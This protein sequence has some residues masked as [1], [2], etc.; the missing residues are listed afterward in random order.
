MYES[1]NKTISEHLRI[2]I[3]RLLDEN[4]GTLNDSLISDLVGPYGFNQSLDKI[5]TELSWLE[6]Q[7]LIEC[8]GE[9][10]IVAT[11]TRRGEDVAKCRVTVPGVK[12]PSP[13]R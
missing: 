4:N 11:L 1:Y 12:R 10:C 3:L 6:E 9:S 13:R 8:S 5:H 7:G 2:T